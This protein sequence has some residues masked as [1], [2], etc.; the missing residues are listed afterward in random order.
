MIKIFISIIFI[1]IIFQKIQSQTFVYSYVPTNDKLWGYLSLDSS[2]NIKPQFINCYDFSEDGIAMTNYLE[3]EWVN[4]LTINGTFLK[5]EVKDYFVRNIQGRA[6]EGFQNGLIVIRNNGKYGCFNTKGALAIP[7]VY[8]YITEFNNNY[9]I[10]K[11]EKKILILNKNGTETPLNKDSIKLCHRFTENMAPFENNNNKYGF[12]DTLGN[13][14]ISPKYAKT[15]FFTGGLVW[16][17]TLENKIGFINTKGEWKI[18]PSFDIVEDFDKESGMALVIRDKQ[19]FYIDTIGNVLEIKDCKQLVSFENGFARINKDGK[20]G[21]INNKGEWVIL[22]IYEN[23]KNFKNG[24]AAVRLNNKWGFI[25]KKGEWIVEPKYT[26][27]GNM[28][29]V[30]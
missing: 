5:P 3:L 6:M 25:N 16:A 19:W 15:G 10:A 12:I 9:A 26:H 27:V 7:L 13:T 21:F 30:K 22:P 8:D 11:K 23:A 14:V 17:R 24:F 28:S 4:F 29:C 20:F 18:P 1:L 2:V